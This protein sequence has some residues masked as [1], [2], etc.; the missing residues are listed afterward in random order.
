MLTSV[1]LALS[2]YIVISFSFIN[3]TCT[4]LKQNKLEL[5]FS[6]AILYPFPLHLLAT[7]HISSNHT[8]DRRPVSQT[9]EQE[10]IQLFLF[11][12][13]SLLVATISDIATAPLSTKVHTLLFFSTFF[14]PNSLFNSFFF[15]YPLQNL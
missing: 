13:E 12:A 14:L 10:K 6:Q 9:H 2:F 4:I 15:I 3:S 1:C 5:I 8:L 7:L 11:L